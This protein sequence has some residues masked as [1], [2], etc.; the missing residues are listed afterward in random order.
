M[1]SPENG[2]TTRCP[3]RSGRMAG[4]RMLLRQERVH[5]D[6]PVR[7]W[8][9]ARLRGAHRSA[10]AP[11]EIAVR[12]AQ[13]EAHAE[14]A[15]V[16]YEDRL[17]RALATVINVLDPDVIV[18]GGGMSNIARLCTACRGSGGDTYSGATRPMTSTPPQSAEAMSTAA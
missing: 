12:A 4:P 14:A 16:R 6:L 11:P 10:E 15:F 18:L 9:D 13:G 1:P 7:P 17:A 3:G 5:R 2:D 8:T